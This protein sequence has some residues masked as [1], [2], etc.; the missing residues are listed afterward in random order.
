VALHKGRILIV[1]DDQAVLY[2][3]RTVLKEIFTTIHIENNPVTAFEAYQKNPYDVVLLD[4]NFG[5]GAT[6]GAEGIQWLKKILE[7]DPEAHIIMNTAY[8]DIDLAVVAM[9]EGAIDFIAK[10]WE[11]E[12]L[13]N[14]VNTVFQLARSKKQLQSIQNQHKAVMANLDQEFG[15]SIGEDPAMQAVFSVIDKVAGTDAN[16]LVTGENGTGKELVARELHR[17]SKRSGKDFIRVDLGAISET[18]FESE[19]FGHEKGAFTDAKERRP[20][21]FELAHSGTL[22]LDEIGN[23]NLSVQA[24]LLTAIQTRQIHRIGSAKPM[25]VDARLICATNRDLYR[26]VEEGEFRQD[27]LYRINTVE[28]KVPPLRERPGDIPLL[29]NHYLGGY[30]KKYEKHKLKILDDTMEALMNYRWP[31]NIR[32]LRHAA[33]RAVILCESE[34]LKTTDF[35]PKPEQSTSQMLLKDEVYEMNEVEKNAI[36]NALKLNKGNISLAARQLGIGRTTLYRKMK[37]YQL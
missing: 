7:Q 30:K 4:M 25:D 6:S 14:T 13:I 2:T 37:K 9:K 12:R 15:I 17:K 10:P 35:L 26:A 22:F 19:L 24:K 29:I 28:I 20:G 8:G 23:L 1:D 21:R 32:E 31:G 18:L 33:E 36:Q 16:V 5:V 3:A 27:L 11:K 34:V